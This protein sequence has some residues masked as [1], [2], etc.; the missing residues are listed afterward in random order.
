[1]RGLQQTSGVRKQKLPD[2]ASGGRG[3]I[4]LTLAGA[5][6]A[7]AGKLHRVLLVV[8]PVVAVVVVVVPV[9]AAAAA[10]AAAVSSRQPLALQDVRCGC[11]ADLSREL[12]VKPI[13]DKDCQ[14]A[15]QRR[16][17]E[18]KGAQGTDS[19]PLRSKVRRT[20]EGSEVLLTWRLTYMSPKKRS[21]LSDFHLYVV[22][23][24][25]RGRRNGRQ[26]ETQCFTVSGLTKTCKRKL[27]CKARYPTRRPPR[28]LSLQ[29]LY[30][31]C[32][33]RQQLGGDSQGE[34]KFNVLKTSLSRKAKRRG[35]QR[36]R[37]G[38]RKQKKNNNK[39]DNNNNNNNSSRKDRREQKAGSRGPDVETCESWLPAVH[40]SNQG[41][42]GVRVDVSPPNPLATHLELALHHGGSSQQMYPTRVPVSQKSYTFTDVT[43]GVYRVSL[44]ALGPLC[45]RAGYIFSREFVNVTGH[46]DPR[47]EDSVRTKRHKHHLRSCSEWQ[48]GITLTTSGRS[49]TARYWPVNHLA[50]SVEIALQKPGTHMQL[51]AREISAT[52]DTYT[53]QNV[54]PGDYRLSIRALGPECRGAGYFYSRHFVSVK[55]PGPLCS[56]WKPAVQAQMVDH[57]SWCLIEVDIDTPPNV[58]AKKIEVALEEQQPGDPL[59]DRIIVQN[60]IS[61]DQEST[62]FNITKTSDKVYRVLVRPCGCTDCKDFQDNGAECVL[63]FTGA[64][65]IAVNY[66]NSM[67]TASLPLGRS[68]YRP[69]KNT[70][71][72]ITP[73]E[74]PTTTTTTTTTTKYL[75]TTITTLVVPETSR[76]TGEQDYGR[77]HMDTPTLLIVIAICAT[78][79]VAAVAVKLLLG[80]C[81]RQPQTRYQPDDE[82]PP[83]RDHLCEGNDVNAAE[84]LE[85][86]ENDR[87][88]RKVVIDH[89]IQNHHGIHQTSPKT[90]APLE[91]N[92]SPPLPSKT[93]VLIIHEHR[94]EYDSTVLKHFIKVIQ[95]A[96]HVKVDFAARREEIERDV[97]VWVSRVTGLCSKVVVVLSEPLLRV[98]RSHEGSKSRQVFSPSAFSNIAP[99][100][101]KALAGQRFARAVFVSFGFRAVRDAGRV[102]GQLLS[103][104]LSPQNQFLTAPTLTRPP[105]FRGSRQPTSSP[106]IPPCPDSEGFS[107]AS[108]RAVGPCSASQG[109]PFATWSERPHW[110]GESSVPSPS[111]PPPPSSSSSDS[112]CSS[113]TATGSHSVSQPCPSSG[114][115][116]PVPRPPSVAPSATGPVSPGP[117]VAVADDA[118]NCCYVHCQDGSSVSFLPPPSY[119]SRD[120]SVSSESP[121]S[122]EADGDEDTADTDTV[123]C[124]CQTEGGSDPAPR[125]RHKS[126]PTTTNPH[127]LPSHPP[128]YH[129]TCL[130]S[131]SGRLPSYSPTHSEGCRNNSTCCC[132]TQVN[133][134]AGLAA[135]AASAKAATSQSVHRSADHRSDPHYRSSADP[136]HKIDKVPGGSHSNSEIS[137]QNRVFPNETAPPPPPSHL[138][139]H[140]ILLQTKDGLRR[141]LRQL[142]TDELTIDSILEGPE[143][144]AFLAEVQSPDRDW[145][146][147]V[148]EENSFYSEV[149]CMNVE[150]R[151]AVE[152]SEP[153]LTDIGVG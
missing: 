9:P 7:A 83:E 45:S 41:E 79:V 111:S 91:I 36:Y 80:K 103:V 67:A 101:M 130:S 87:T 126:A 14:P 32:S 27:S 94:G 35:V 31:H 8:V 127:A 148:P 99:L 49:V 52:N 92:R 85:H 38:K 61:L 46:G 73:K 62:V 140:P 118:E 122:R 33:R 68:M 57:G 5:T 134:T 90:V 120:H 74:V 97:V 42:G 25:S 123:F 100:V 119:S 56:H 59:N 40:L 23:K 4:S 86:N 51:H 60:F 138:P 43:K 153:D 151:V 6:P 54:E 50:S 44:R 149:H 133:S 131:P 48:P 104:Y 136:L 139:D 65:V 3:K 106:L 135:A 58:V 93:W 22:T 11:G 144:R 30:Q 121:A 82:R 150:H 88:G 96:V 143:T 1:M 76:T 105:P 15:Q 132:G 141:L 124:A 113:G 107:E 53:F 26:T 39:N 17:Q 21:R 81:C 128:P 28:A 77:T 125:A 47:A 115:G 146:Q 84:H 66:Q 152:H 98:C 145:K 20:Q 70:T 24:A 137:L 110:H 147:R 129:S 55:D 16:P 112:P 102:F 117:A 78:I 114:V 109:K 12:L 142:C 69:G 108:P 64:H 34:G 10:A 2:G 71:T 37:S 116:V 63:S 18:L 75:T 13:A 89:F 19:Y 29:V 72:E 95:R